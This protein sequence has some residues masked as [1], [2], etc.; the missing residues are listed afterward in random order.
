[1]K[2]EGEAGGLALSCIRGII[3]SGGWG[4]DYKPCDPKPD[5]AEICAVIDREH[6]DHPAKGVIH[7]SIGHVPPAKLLLGIASK[8]A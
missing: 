8:A 6:L 3:D 5:E 4:Q 2:I 1:M 7:S